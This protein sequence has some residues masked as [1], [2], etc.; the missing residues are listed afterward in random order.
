MNN[1]IVTVDGHTNA[2]YLALEALEK[3]CEGMIDVTIDEYSFQHV[4]TQ[5]PDFSEDELSYEIQTM[6]D[7]ARYALHHG[8]TIE[9]RHKVFKASVS[10]TYV[11]VPAKPVSE[12]VAD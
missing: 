10:E 4:A 11:E 7:L 3:L 9:S 5:V 8:F 1:V 2:A 6:A 12:P